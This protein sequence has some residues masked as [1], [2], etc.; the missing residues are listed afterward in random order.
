MQTE[1]ELDMQGKLLQAQREAAYYQK[2]A[3]DCGDRRLKESEDLSNLIAKLR[4]TEKELVRARDMLELRV[5]ERTAELEH[6]NM[7]LTE[8]MY[9]RQQI[10]EELRHSNAALEEEQL[11]LEAKVHERTQKIL[12][13]QRERVREL[14]T[15]LIPLLGHVILMPLIG[16]IDDDRAQQVL[17][18]LLVGVDTY[19]ATVA[20]LD[21]TG[22]RGLD[23][24]TAHTPASN[25]RCSLA[26]GRSHHHWYPTCHSPDYRLSRSRPERYHDTQYSPGWHN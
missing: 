18:T 16:T 8:E 2:L 9:E 5:Q 19:N 7:R 20:I 22:I 23:S 21:V 15:P 13:M 4:A 12:H 1:K 24:E 25:T 3:R 11:H 26:W 10:A 6:T 17:E 14:A